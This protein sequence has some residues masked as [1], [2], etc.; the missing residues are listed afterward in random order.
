M[1]NTRRFLLIILL[2]TALEAQADPR[3]QASLGEQYHGWAADTVLPFNG[4]EFL[5]PF[6][7]TYAANPNWWLSGSTAFAT[8]SYTD[9]VAGKETQDLTALTASTVTSDY[10]F[11]AFG[12]TNLFEASLTLPTGDPAWESKQVAASIPTL[13]LNSRYFSEGWNVSALYGL[14][15]PTT[16]GNVEWGASLGYSYAGP[17]DPNFGYMAGVQL[18]MGDSLFLAVNRTEAFAGNKSSALRVTAMAFRPTQ[19]NGLNDFQLGTNVGLSYNFYDPAGFSWG[20]S[21]QAY[22]LADRYY[23]NSLGQVVYG[24]EIYGSSGFR[25]ALT[26]SYSWGNFTLGAQFQAVFVNGYPPQDYSGLYNGGGYVL[27]L[28]PSYLLGL[29]ANSDLRLNG[30][31][32]FI[33]A[34]NASQD[35]DADVNYHHWTLGASYEIKI[36]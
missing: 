30:G 29:D 35:F 18:K 4:S 14:S 21:A 25:F 20:F 23:Y 13:F 36:F 26:P 19:M 7:V 1:R 32:D 15:F 5:S 28:A 12:L 22:N 27:G 8:G 34:R 11:K 33:I 17:Y 24:Q 31:Y 3:G 10:Y 9:S 6:F 16:G 2:A